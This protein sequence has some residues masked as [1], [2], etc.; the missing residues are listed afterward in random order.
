MGMMKGAFLHMRKEETGSSL[1]TALDL[2]LRRGGAVSVPPEPGP[3]LGPGVE[4]PRREERGTEKGREDAGGAPAERRTDGGARVSITAGTAASRGGLT[5]RRSPCA[6]GRTV[7]PSGGAA[8]CQRDG[9]GGRPRGRRAPVGPGDRVGEPGP[10]GPGESL[11]IPAQTD[12]VPQIQ[13]AGRASALAAGQGTPVDGAGPGAGR[14]AAGREPDAVECGGV[15]SLLLDNRH[16]IPSKLGMVTSGQV[17]HNG[18][19]LIAPDGSVIEQVVASR[20][21]FR[22]KSFEPVEREKRGPRGGDSSEGDGRG[23]A[24]ARKELFRCAL[25]NPDL[26][27]FLTF[28]QSPELVADRYDYKAAVHRLGVWLDNRVR[29]RGLKYIFVPELHQD[30]AIHW[31][32]LCN[33]DALRLVDSGHKDRGGEVIFNVAD[34]K[35]GFT[36]ATRVRDHGAACRYVSKYITKQM[37]AKTIGGRYWLHGGRLE[38]PVE[39]LF[40]CSGIPEGASRVDVEE[41]RLSL[42]YGGRLSECQLGN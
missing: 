19:M 18:R 20:P 32:G 31:H 24:R 5:P 41:A 30:G 13:T 6:D 1:Y 11:R 26:D 33:G 25:C 34:W 8:A 21:I 14:P 38:K 7:L 37:D 36:T 22:D 40:D 27:T 17:Y 39:R 28:T 12:F 10:E 42:W 35:F 16:S 9:R 15:S 2:D 23:A 29:R 3:A 4:P